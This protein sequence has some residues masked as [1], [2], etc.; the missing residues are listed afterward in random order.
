MRNVCYIGMSGGKLRKQIMKLKTYEINRKPIQ[1][2]CKQPSMWGTCADNN[3][4][5]PLIYFQKPKWMAQESF[6]LIVKNIKLDLPQNTE[7][8]REESKLR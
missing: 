3:G 6:E 7:I 4:I 5:Y 1:G 8:K 2:I